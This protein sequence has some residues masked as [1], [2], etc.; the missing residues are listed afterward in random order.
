MKNLV[1]SSQEYPGPPPPT[2]NENLGR[3]WHCSQEYPLLQVKNWAVISP[4]L[5]PAKENWSELG[6]FSFE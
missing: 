2:E 6:T 4:P 3:T 5:S 1:L